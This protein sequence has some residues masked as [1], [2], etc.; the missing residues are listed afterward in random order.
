MFHGAQDGAADGGVTTIT[1]ML[2]YNLC[3]NKVKRPSLEGYNDHYSVIME[4]F[5]Y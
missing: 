3:F 1:E 5:Y 4:K 2:C